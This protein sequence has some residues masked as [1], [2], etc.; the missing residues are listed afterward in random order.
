MF[1]D[2]ELSAVLQKLGGQRSRRETPSNVDTS[3]VSK[4]EE[5]ALNS[6]TVDKLKIKETQSVEHMRLS[7]LRY[8]SLICVQ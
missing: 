3:S 8:Q 6:K 1:T 4:Q 2:K 5:T 7:P